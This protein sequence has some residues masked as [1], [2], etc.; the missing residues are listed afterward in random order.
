MMENIYFEW[1]RKTLWK[2]SRMP[3]NLSMGER[4]RETETAGK[5]SCCLWSE[6]PQGGRLTP[7]LPVVSGNNLEQCLLY[8]QDSHFLM[9]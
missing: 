1:K 3:L 6:L 5:N 7:N 4:A 2:P 8:P 9:I